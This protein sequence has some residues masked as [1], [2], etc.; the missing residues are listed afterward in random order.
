MSY[1]MPPQPKVIVYNTVNS[2][3]FIKE[4]S[5]IK[6]KLF[7]FLL[8]S[9]MGAVKPHCKPVCTGT[10]NNWTNYKFGKNGITQRG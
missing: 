9:S 8:G 4:N 3:L 2:W 6:M 7:G 5:N 1:F 10:A